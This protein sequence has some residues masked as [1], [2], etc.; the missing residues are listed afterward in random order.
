LRRAASPFETPASRAPQGEAELLHK[1]SDALR[2][3][4]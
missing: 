1:P 2:A 4:S 3:L